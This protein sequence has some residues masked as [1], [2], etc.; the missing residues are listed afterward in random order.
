MIVIGIDP[1]KETGFAVYDLMEK[2]LIDLRTLD[3]WSAY[4]LV[5]EYSKTRTIKCVVIE[6][7]K[8]KHVFH[9][10]GANA[11][12]NQRMGVHVG[13]VI[14]ESELLAQ[15]LEGWAFNV[16]RVEPVGKKDAATF[17][18][19]FPEWEGRTNQ[20]NRDAAFMC[21]RRCPDAD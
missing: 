4:A 3:F 12:A 9:K 17:K 6:A 18:K 7:P 15:G 14:R 2:K 8:N 16:K 21:L 5:V 13:S 1:G 10:P 19:A 20:H 11:A